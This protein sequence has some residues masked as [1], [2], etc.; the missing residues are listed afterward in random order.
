M[1]MDDT[2]SNAE[3]IPGRSDAQHPA[4]PDEVLPE[5]CTKII[6]FSSVLSRPYSANRR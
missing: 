5:T 2:S 1:V 6:K 3:F 4:L